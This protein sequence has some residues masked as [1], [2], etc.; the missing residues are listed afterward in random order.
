VRVTRIDNPES[1]KERIALAAAD[2]GPDPWETA[3]ETLTDGAIVR[4]RVVR[5]A[6]FGAFVNL[7][8]GIDGLVHVSELPP[9]PENAPGP[10]AVQPGDEI[11]VRIVRVDLEK[12]RVSL[13]THLQPP[14]ARPP[15]EMRDA[16]D[17]RP[18]RDGRD[19]RRPRRDRDRDRDT[20][21]RD[22]DATPFSTGGSL[23]HN[24]AEQLGALRRKLQDRP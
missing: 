4:G 3:R 20:R 1:G 22:R 21:D 18:G 12:K 9:L 14:A 5:L 17:S 8:P 6:E 16:H 24:M 13:S 19:A 15:R 2:L 10:L 23:T 7:L 11:E